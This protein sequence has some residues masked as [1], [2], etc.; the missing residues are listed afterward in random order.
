MR[1]GGGFDEIGTNDM[2]RSKPR[3]QEPGGVYDLVVGCYRELLVKAWDME[4][5]ITTLAEQE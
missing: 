2:N 1:R 3:R 5:G 4:Y